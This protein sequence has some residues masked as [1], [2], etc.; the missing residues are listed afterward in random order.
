M[1]NW[2]SQI[3]RHVN[4]SHQFKFQVRMIPCGGNTQTTVVQL[5]GVG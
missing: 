4:F 5:S 2:K 1:V 3:Y